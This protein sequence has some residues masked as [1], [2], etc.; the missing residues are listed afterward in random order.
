MKNIKQVHLKHFTFHPVTS[1][2]QGSSRMRR[3]TYLD[4]EVTVT[5]MQRGSRHYF[6]R[7]V[8]LVGGAAVC[9]TGVLHMVYMYWCVTYW[10]DW[11]TCMSGFHASTWMALART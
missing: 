2:Q 9:C 11:P 3:E 4:K 7:N 10:A 6:K 8:H 5:L 1:T